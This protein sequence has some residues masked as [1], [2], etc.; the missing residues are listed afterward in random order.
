MMTPPSSLA[1]PKIRRVRILLVDDAAQVRH[2]LAQLLE[3]SGMVQIVGQAG[4]GLEAVRL[5]AELSPDVIVMDLEMPVLDGLEATRQIK[6]LEP[7]PR[8]IILSVHAGPAQE[9]RSREAGADGFIVKGASY[10]ILLYAILSK[11][12]PNNSVERGEES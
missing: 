7:A 5:A 6:T 4:D 3:L 12:G 8:V 11:D 2:E 10:Q 1:N 9:E